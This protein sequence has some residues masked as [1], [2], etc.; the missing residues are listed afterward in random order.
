MDQRLEK[1][2][3]MQR[4]MHERLQ[5]PMQ[6][7]LDKIQEDMMEKLIKAQKDAMAELTHLLTRGVDKGKGPM[8]NHGEGSEDPLYPPGFTPP[9]VRTQTEMYPRGP[10]VTIMPQQLQTDFDEAAKEGKASTELPKQWEDRYRWLEEKFKAL[11]SADSNQGIDTKD[12]SLVPDLVLPPKFKMLE[13]EKYNGTRCPGAH[14]TMFCRRMTGY[15]NNDQLLI[16]Y[17]QDSLVGAA[18]KLYNQLSRIK[19]SSWRDLAQAF[20]KQYSH[21]TDMTPDRITL[22]NL[23][24]KPSESFRQYAQRWREV[25][26]QVQPPL[27]ERETTMLFINTLRAQFITHMLGSATKSF[28]DI[29]MNG[30]MIENSI[31]NG[32]IEAGESNKRS[33]SRRKENKVNNVNAYNKLI[34]VN[35]PRKVITGQ[36]GSTRQEFGVRQGTEKPQFTP[37]L[38]TYKEL[39]HNFFNA[40][41]VS[42][43]YL[44]PLQPPYPKWYDVSAQCDYHAGI[45]GHSIE[46]CTAFKKLVEKFIGMGVIKFDE[47]PNTENLLPNHIDKGVNM[48][49]ESRGE[50]VKNDIAEVKTPLKWVWRQMAIRGLVISNFEEGYEAENYC[51][52][53]HEVG[54]EIQECEGFRALVQSMMDNKEMRFYEEAEDKGNI[55]ASELAAKTVEM[56][57]PVVIISRPRSDGSRVQTT[58]KIVIQKPSNFLYKDDK[59]VPWN[60]G[61]NVTILGKGAERNQEAEPSREEN[62]KKE[63]KKGEAVEV[64]P[65]VNEPVKEEEA[66]E[67]LKFLKRSK[68]SVVEQLCKQSACISM[69]AL[70]LSSEA[71]RNALLKVLNE[72]YVADDI[73]VNKLDHRLP[74]DSSY[75]KAC[76][77]IVR[78]FD[79]ME[80][81]VMGRIE[82]K[83]WSSRLD[84]ALWALWIACKTL[85][86]MSP[87]QLV[88]VKACHLSVELEHKAMWAIKQVNMDYEAAGKK[89]AIEYH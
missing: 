11:E 48:M 46:N 44:T 34:T 17:F 65:L 59:M 55:C 87:Y 41:V 29:V 3:Q 14:I 81:R 49:S 54:H 76:Q 32:K 57:H 43:H 21:V 73:S 13:F 60:Y 7:R 52:F 2:E 56:N 1:L 4:D 18:S 89:K 35:Q 84:D 10:S 64:E 30:E 69:L 5:T 24:K 36:Q 88:F 28:S 53:H 67:F 68:Y 72:T 27:L 22:Q 74:V 62:W 47:S 71:H 63:Q 25:A 19:I 26:I 37:I 78:A 16:H 80:K 39:Y 9:N 86:G 38:M 58:P 79:G 85:L 83:D 6:E 50:E 70:L 77:S 51:E 82:R 61:C 12:L 8:A 23:E 42:P 15:V 45:T 33:A 20:M 40:H 31:R 66:K 75:M